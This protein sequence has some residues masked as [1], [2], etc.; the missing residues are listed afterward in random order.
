MKRTTTVLDTL[1]PKNVATAA[2]TPTICRSNIHEDEWEIVANAV[3]KRQAEFCG[4][5][6]CAHQALQRLGVS[7]EVILQNKDRSPRWP[8]KV[9]GSISHTRGYCAAAVANR[10]DIEGIGLDVEQDTPLDEELF[11]LVCSAG[12]RRWLSSHPPGDG[13]RYAKILFSVK[14]A[15]FKCQFPITREFIEYSQAEITLDV[16]RLSFC[17]A[18]PQASA[19]ASLVCSNIRG[20][21]RVQSGFIFSGATI[22]P[23]V[24]G[25][26][27]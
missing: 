24:S 8:D 6:M 10:N 15:A 14:E 22:V 21:F 25:N 2:S 13:G 4:G 5:R 18:V 23:P 26:V 20:R 27:W 12:E 7:A 17:V 9:T 3:P 11:E 19:K 1:F 16:N